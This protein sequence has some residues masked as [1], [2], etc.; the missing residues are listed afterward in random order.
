VP[1]RATLRFCD[2][3]YELGMLPL[4]TVVL[5]LCIILFLCPHILQGPSMPSTQPTTEVQGPSVPSPHPPYSRAPQCRHSSPPT[6][7]VQGPSG[8]PCAASCGCISGDTATLLSKDSRYRRRG[9]KPRAGAWPSLMAC[10]C[11]RVRVCVHVCMCMC[12]FACVCAFACVRVC[13]HVCVCMCV[14]LHVC[15]CV[16]ACVCVCV[17]ERER[18]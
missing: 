14:C 6:T 10:T 2:R 1:S 3:P 12:V 11:A 16:C 9:I 18:E 13:V 17:R 7:F 8:T 15:L 4:Q 5:F